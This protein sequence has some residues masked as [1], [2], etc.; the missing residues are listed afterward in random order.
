MVGIVG[1]LAKVMSFQY[2][3]GM[4]GMTMMAYPL[5]IT[6]MFR[7]GID[8]FPQKQIVSRRASGELDRYSYRQLTRIQALAF[9]RRWAPTRSRRPLDLAIEHLCHFFASVVAAR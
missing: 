9:R 7:R 3:G 5:T 4:F 8:L 6:S 2:G 1:V